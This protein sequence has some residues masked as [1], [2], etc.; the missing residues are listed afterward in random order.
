MSHIASNTTKVAFATYRL[1]SYAKELYLESGEVAQWL[2]PLTVLP[3]V[4][5]S[6]PSYH[7]VAH[8]HV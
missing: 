5:S 4:L 6:I 1:I 3:E 2:R 8:N 7:M